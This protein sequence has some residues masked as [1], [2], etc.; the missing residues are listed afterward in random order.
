MFCPYVPVWRVLFACLME[1]LENLILYIDDDSTN[2][3][4]FKNTFLG[5][6]NVST[7]ESTSQAE[8]LIRNHQ[9]KV[10]L[11]DI[12]MPHET[13]LDFFKRIRFGTLEPVLI[14]LTAHV[15]NSLL[16][17][18]LHQGKIFRY[19]T[20]PWNSGELR[21]TIE[22]AIQTFDLHYQNRMLYNQI[23]ESEQKFH[24][25]FQYSQDAI[26]IFDAREYIR[27]AN[28]AFL[29][30][31]KK[32]ITDVRKSRITDFLDDEA[33]PS[34]SRRLKQLTH[35]GNSIKEYTLDIPG[36][37]RRVVEANS[38][39]IEYKGE[40]AV[41]SI[42]R[43]ITGRKQ[44]EKALLDA[45][46][47]AEE[48]ERRRIAKDLHDGL[49]PILATLNMYLEWL[50]EKGKTDEHPDILDLSVAS[51]KEAM[52]TLKN[53]SNNLSPHMLEKFGLL[54]AISSFV[55][56]IKKV[57]RV[58]FTIDSNVNDRLSPVVEI[59]L[60]RIV[61]EC[62]NNTLKHSQSTEIV[63]QLRKNE[64]T[65]HLVYTDNGKG[66]DIASAMK[67]HSGM[68]LH[69]IQ[70]RINT[71]GGRVNFKSSGDFGTEISA[72]III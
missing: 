52:I 23:E 41:L 55:E 31:V 50:H 22:Q 67:G 28:D 1:N 69:N 19:V 40:N 24:N 35:V 38:C 32:D 70:N 30:V 54:S 21:H 44:Q 65:L 9:F 14:I 71:L 45:V 16:L 39:I 6:F 13:G 36:V 15:S 18:A 34:F 58:K 53:I 51:V 57:S 5:D 33:K 4:L 64:N 62:I 68:G 12:S 27:E 7:A 48:K 25:I 42:I 56:L 37:G 2:L 29:R 60:Y 49:G 11:S 61:T 59:S 20:K 17:Q 43:D 10:I 72:E 26:V 8:E 47:E 66:F 3:M 63:I 46:I